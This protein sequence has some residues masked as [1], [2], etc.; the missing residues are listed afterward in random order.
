M[1]TIASHTAGLSRL[2]WTAGIVIGAS[3]P[4]WPQQPFWIP[5]LLFLCIGWRFA[6]RQL[7]WPAPG[8]WLMGLITILAFGGVVLEYGTINGL[9]PGSALL[10]VMVSL[11][12]LEAKSQR[13]HLLL[14][15]I[16]YFL[17]FA[18][19][20][21]GGGLIQ[22][23]YLLAFVWITTL[24]LLQVGRTGP[25]LASGPTAKLAGKLLLQSVPLM[26]V[27]FVLFPRLPGPLWSMPNDDTAASSGLSDEMSP[28]DVTSLGLSD[29]IAFR[30][31][32]SGQTPAPS[33]LYWRG[34]VLTRFDGR[35]WKM[36]QGTRGRNED[37]IEYL[38]QV[39]RYRVM[40]E[41]DTR[42]PFALDMPAAWEAGERSWSIA[43]TSDY[44][45]VFWPPDAGS[46]RRQYSVTSYSDYRA[47]EILSA[48]EQRSF[49]ALPQDLN[50][51][52]RALIDELTAD[53]PDTQTLIDRALD[54]FRGDEFFY[55]LTPPA[56]GQDAV[57]DFIFETRE[58]F[59]EHY[60]SAFAVMMRM[61]GIPARV[62]M[63]Y[64]GGELNGI[65]DYYII[66]Q[67]NAHAWTEVWLPDQGWVRVDP[68]SAVAPERIAFG[69]TRTNTALATTMAQRIGRM[70][71]LRHLSLTWDAVN[72][73]WND[74]VIGYGPRLQRNLLQ[75]LG[76]ERLR[77]AE[78]LALAILTA[79][80]MLIA[81]TVYF[82]V[83]IRHLDPVDPAAR[84]YRRFLRKLK[85]HRVEPMRTGETPQS[86]AARAE[87]RL[88]AA[89]EAIANITE[90]YLA[91][92]YEPDRSG[93]ALARLQERV[94][95]FRP[96]C[97]PA[98]R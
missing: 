19:L 21:S 40:L 16:A 48:A 22:G 97:A 24:G 98:S 73:L 4:H 68:I 35:T 2:A 56:L 58:G 54:V 64:Q 81:L 26:L 85:R 60:A 70:T 87:A 53:A 8:R 96:D 43:M 52:T 1:S 62:V 92:R 61:A 15:V 59:C 6:V 20:L 82:G 84:C 90:L 49:T 17:V 77:W 95:S 71:L 34:P 12:F 57:D 27:L 55:T 75:Y 41:P 18:S 74:W 89:A 47:R 91:A 32:F 76:F 93:R 29:A 72:T 31:E 83:Q 25:L 3:L 14:T 80:G 88:P 44:Q 63:G 51:R 78:L 30:V 45:L 42:W 37:T 13:D 9:G 50:P 86:F 10:I 36:P 66:R 69:S 67:S 33:E 38:D 28:G 23:L 5:L 7:R 65:G 46:R 39:S 94:R 11:K 79:A